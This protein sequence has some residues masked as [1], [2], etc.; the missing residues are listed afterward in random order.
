MGSNDKL[1]L[2]FDEIETLIKEIEDISSYGKRINAS[3]NAVAEEFQKFQQNIS[4]QISSVAETEFGKYRVEYEKN[5]KE[6]FET[7]IAEIKTSRRGS[8]CRIEF[9]RSRSS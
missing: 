4:R 9:V 2:V 5:F 7:A 3:A 6:S 1:R 8:K